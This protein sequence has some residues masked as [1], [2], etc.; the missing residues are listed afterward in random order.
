MAQKPRK[1]SLWPDQNELNAARRRLPKFE[2]HA[3][4]SLVRE[5]GAQGGDL[6]LLLA[7]RRRNERQMI[8]LLRSLGVDPARPGAWQR[9]FFLLA[10]Y[11]HGVGHLLFDRQRT[12]RNAARWSRRDD[13]RLMAEV[14]KLRASSRVSERAAVIQSRFLDP[15]LHR[16]FPYREQQNR[17]DFHSSVKN[18]I[19]KRQ[20]ALWRHLQYL[21]AQSRHE[22]ILKQVLGSDWNAHDTAECA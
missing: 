5:A 1:G 21:K 22:S 14:T 4:R 6:A 9:G 16:V 8:D 15:K 20:A 18:E 7:F 2:R 17:T 3:V 11:H 19:R 13:L 10:H 12:N